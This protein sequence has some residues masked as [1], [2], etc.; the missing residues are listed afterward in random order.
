MNSKM[1]LATVSLALIVGGSS[2]AMAGGKKAPVDPRTAYKSAPGNP[3]GRQSWCDTNPQCN[4]WGKW[5][6]MAKAG[7]KF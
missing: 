4:G 6:E 2:I 5:Q 3:N 1:I 7:A